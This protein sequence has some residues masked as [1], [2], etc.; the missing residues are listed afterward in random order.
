MT[1]ILRSEGLHKRFGAVSAAT[2]VN[3]SV[4]EGEIVAL[5]G[6]NGA[7]KTSYVNM[8]TGYLRPDAGR[9]RLGETDLVGMKPRQVT[10]AGIC[11]SFQVAQIFGELTVLENVLIA[12]AIARGGASSGWRG[13]SRPEWISASEEVLEQFQL[14][15][16][17][18][19]TAGTLAQGV[20]KLLDIA[21]ATVASPRLM[22]LDEPTSGISVDE[23]FAVM[24]T[25]MSALRQRGV[26]VLF[27]EHDMEIVERYARRVAAF[28]D[29]R[30]IADGD[31][32]EVL[33][34]PD[35]RQ[36]VV[37]GELHRRGGQGGGE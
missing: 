27:V 29:G 32:A 36:Y 19:A 2:D 3:L 8:V 22:M 17:R 6:A 20:R 16:H 35:V 14:A 9:I 31:A 12:L 37:G 28:Y 30:I 15:E 5:I 23:K 26:T 33:V 7:G 25:L 10:R 13:L 1:A 24:D 4:E 34:D 11:R 18:D 21:M